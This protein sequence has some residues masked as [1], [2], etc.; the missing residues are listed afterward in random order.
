MIP[1]LL[2][3][4][5]NPMQFNQ[6]HVH[7]SPSIYNQVIGPLH[8]REELNC[9]NLCR[10][11]W[12]RMC[13]AWGDA[14]FLHYIYTI[15][16]VVVVVVVVV[17]VIIII[18]LLLLLFIIIIIIKRIYLNWKYELNYEVEKFL[19][20]CKLFSSGDDDE[21]MNWHTTAACVGPTSFR[22]RQ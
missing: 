18:L 7:Q 5:L 8:V 17:V 13:H 3:L 22:I 4:W 9:H 12:P 20:G 21:W 14:L 1:I 6:S 16:I 2:I 11:P 19:M 10:S 15:I